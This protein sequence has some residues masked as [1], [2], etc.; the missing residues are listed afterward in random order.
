MKR[1]AALTAAITT[2]VLLASA[3]AS[4]AGQLQRDVAA[5]RAVGVTGVLA[6]VSTP[7]G[8]R[9]ARAG[10]AKLGTRRPV[11]FG[12]H[13]RIGSATKAFVAAVVLQ[14]VS[15]GRLSLE[16]P[17][18]R[19][20]PGVVSGRGNDGRRITIRQLLQHTSGIH[21]YFPEL[22][23]N[24][25]EQFRRHRFDVVTPEQA[26]AIAMRHRPAFSPGAGWSYSNTN[27]TLL[28][29]VIRS[30]TG[31]DW[32]AE[33]RTRI[34]DPLGLRKTSLRGRHRG[35]PSPFVHGYEQFTAR[36]PLV[37]VT[38]MV[39]NSA[40][41]GLVGTPGDVNRFLRAFLSG[42]LVAPRELR[43]LRDTVPA[44][45]LQAFWPGVRDGLGL[46]RLPLSC[47]GWYW[48]H[49]GDHYGFMTRNGVTSDGR[50]SATVSMATEFSG[51]ERRLVRQDAA[52]R[53]LVDRALCG[54]RARRGEMTARPDRATA[55]QRDHHASPYPI[56]RST[57]VRWWR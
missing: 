25:P 35:L 1:K 38:R 13:V 49:S 30:V 41:G 19:W 10:V 31:N 32:Y 52:A 55:H 5:I 24:T 17:V 39:D 11:P 33:L 43:E 29:M 3:P 8:R 53:R 22:P 40:D 50:R 12:A 36:G 47:G 7:G 44:K 16:D 21:D 46:F 57:L 6:Q 45:A 9:K 51:D 20:L 42:R 23:L 18:D 28:G 56:S 48:S 54:T 34:L 2:T 26:V 27:Y 14:L 37:D 15:E 4:P